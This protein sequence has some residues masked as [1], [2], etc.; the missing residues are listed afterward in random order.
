MIRRNKSHDIRRDYRINERIFADTLRVVD[1]EGK[2]VGVISKREALDLARERGIDLVEFAPMAK[3]PVAK[4]VDFNKFLY[5]EQKK[6]Q[7][8]KRNAKVSETKEVRLGPHMSENDMQTMIKRTRE[9]LDDGDK[10]RL[11]VKFRGRQIIHPEFGYEVIKKMV[12]GV[13]DIS[14]ID[15]DPHLEGKQLI[16]LISVERKK[17]QPGPK[18]QAENEDY[19]KTEDK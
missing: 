5:Q 1:A 4:L 7:E 13:A 18:V 17:N 2:Q 3:P 8:E 12:A 11:V 14:K 9:F 16:A 15:R 19:A 6:K 10:V